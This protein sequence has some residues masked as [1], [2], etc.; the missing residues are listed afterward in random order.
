MIPIILLILLPQY[1]CKKNVPPIEPYRSTEY[2]VNQLWKA[3][4]ENE[5]KLSINNVFHKVGIAIIDDVCCHSK[6]EV[7]IE[8]VEKLTTYQLNFINNGYF[9]DI[10]TIFSMLKKSLPEEIIVD[11]SQFILELQL[12]ADNAFQ[13]KEL[14]SNAQ[15]V[16]MLSES[17]HI[18]NEAPTITLD[19]ELLPI[20]AFLLNIWI[21]E[22]YLQ[23]KVLK[24]SLGDFEDCLEDCQD[25]LFWCLVSA[26]FWYELGMIG[27]LTGYG[28]AIACLPGTWPAIAIYLSGAGLTAG[29]IAGIKAIWDSYQDA[30]DE[31]EQEAE[32][33]INGCH[34]QGG[35]K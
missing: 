3:N 4:N 30:I 15:L 7:S 13:Q 19:K 35:G 8:D 14:P 21:F 1:G 2:L 16:I 26:I 33:C 28:I 24:S 10:G 32:D 5:I 31:C 20:Q 25:D 9:L 12:Q 11:S 17:E 6:L 29:A 18:S 23:N 34:D 22:N 27:A